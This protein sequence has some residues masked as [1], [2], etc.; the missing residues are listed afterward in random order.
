MVGVVANRR[1]GVPGQA[2]EG[3]GP[4]DRL[5]RAGRQLFAAYGYAHTSVESL[6]EQAK[7]PV[8][9]FRQEFVS[10][11]VLLMAIYDEV[12]THGLR[13]AENALMAEGMEDCP[14]AQRVRL[15]FDAY[16]RAVTEDPCA[17][18]VA[19]VEVL[20]V[21]REVDNHLA[22]WRAM[23][24]EFLTSEAERAVR[25]GEAVPSD[26]TVTVTVLNHS[27]DELMAHHGRRPRQV[28]AEWLTDEL[29]RLSL[30]MILPS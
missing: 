15:L 26:H 9:I 10:R 30:A 12:A 24:I 18:R 1:N 7:V 29:T 5:L 2:M 28:D 4:R 6:C 23:W 11:E 21:S 16:V 13:A 27:V 25:R 20:G 17:A 22:T 8:H 19:F 3:P 14:T